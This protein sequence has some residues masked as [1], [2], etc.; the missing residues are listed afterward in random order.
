MIETW[1]VLQEDERWSH[2]ANHARDFWPEPSAVGLRCPFTGD[3][4]RLTGE[5]GR[6]QI[7]AAAK[8][9]AIKG[10]EVVPDRRAIQGRVFHPCHEGGRG[11]SVPFNETQTAVAITE[12]KPD[13]ELKPSNPGT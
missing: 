1:D 3:R 4:D 13:S 8:R 10:R 2:L 7:H 6:D 11:E 9:L 5:A 12:G